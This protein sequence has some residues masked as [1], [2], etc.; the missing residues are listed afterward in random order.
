MGINIRSPWG[1]PIN[2]A[3]I[4][5]VE[6]FTKKNS[7][8]VFLEDNKTY[9]IEGEVDLNGLN[10][11]AGRNVSIFGYGPENCILKSTGLETA[12]INSACNIQ[13]QNVTISAKIAL[14][15]DASTN[16]G[17][18]IDWFKV[19]FLN[20]ETIGTVK[21]YDNFIGLV[22]GF[23]NSDGLSFDGTI[24]TIGIESSIFTGTGNGVSVILPASLTITRRI[25]IIYSA[26]V[27]FG[28]QIGIKYE[29]ATIPNEGFILDTV[30]FSGGGV[31]LDGITESNNKSLISN[32]KG[33]DNS[34]NIGQLIIEGNAV[35]T[36]ITKNVYTKGEGAS[37]AGP[38]VEKFVHA[39]GRLQ[40][41]GALTGYFKI[42]TVI[43]LFSG[44]NNV[45][46][47][48]IA[49]NGIVNESVTQKTTTSGAGRSENVVFSDIESLSPGDF[50]EIYITNQTAS[51]NVTVE[52][53]NMIIERL[54]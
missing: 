46:G 32:T 33:V 11:V 18:A 44:N 14:N 39:S 47:I 5:S 49:K 19:N 21:S 38:Y 27:V 6:D 41:E 2:S 7:T 37:I 25:R 52:N 17:S 53:L 10:I 36:V 54:N 45:I 22:L 23:L 51:N 30:N 29:G 26:F 31:Y 8:S 9:I 43:S 13:I 12:F 34:A 35:P 24:G 20:C 3:Q 42:T 50:V 28:S 15:L 40:Y 4:Q 48:R 1:G 16:P